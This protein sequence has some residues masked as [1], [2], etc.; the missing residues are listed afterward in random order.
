M[1]SFQGSNAKPPDQLHL[2]NSLTRK[3]SN[4]VLCTSRRL[5]HAAV[6]AGDVA[7]ATEESNFK[8]FKF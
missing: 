7:R 2:I 5:P 6:S 4:A 3:H 1:V 8:V